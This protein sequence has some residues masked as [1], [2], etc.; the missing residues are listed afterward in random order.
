MRHHMRMHNW[1]F[2]CCCPAAP[3]LSPT[4]TPASCLPSINQPIS[5][6][7]VLASGFS[8][9]VQRGEAQAA[10]INE[11]RQRMDQIKELAHKLRL[12][13]VRGR[14][15]VGCGWGCGREG[16]EGEGGCW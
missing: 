4:N 1:L 3:C 10:A 2:L 8:D 11:N 14:G 5:L 13:L 12:R 16:R 9:L 15:G 6:W 7:P